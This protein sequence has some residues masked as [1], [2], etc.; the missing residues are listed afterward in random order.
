M[1]KSRRLLPVQ[2]LAEQRKKQAELRL[3][4]AQQQLQAEQQK[5][6]QLQDYLQE[7]QKDLLQTGQAGVTIEKLQR[8]QAFKQRLVDALDQ[9]K[10]QID[11]CEQTLA[12]TKQAWQMAR[13]K[14][15]AM[16]SLVQRIQQQERQ[17][18]DKRQQQ[19][20]DELALLRPRQD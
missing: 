12:Y 14:E 16:G 3:G 2:N 17:Q 20:M 5:L 15:R 8:L 19:Q 1:K 9:Q 18:E 6:L 7:Y 13:G 11:F 4:Q 10:K